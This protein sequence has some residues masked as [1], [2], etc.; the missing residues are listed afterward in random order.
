MFAG[1]ILDPSDPQYRGVAV[2]RSFWKLLAYVVDERLRARAFMLTQDL[3]GLEPITF[4]EQ[5]VIHGLSVPDLQERTG[6][7]F[8]QVL[9]DADQAHQG[10]R[11]AQAIVQDPYDIRW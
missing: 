6:L 7:H 10:L 11:P 1:P 2:P 9:R 8:A 4:D 5:Y 3:A